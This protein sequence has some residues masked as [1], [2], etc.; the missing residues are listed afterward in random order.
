MGSSVYVT[1]QSAQAMDIKVVKQGPT[2]TYDDSLMAKSVTVA[3]GQSRADVLDI[4][5]GFTLNASDAIDTVEVQMSIGGTF[6]GA[7]VVMIDSRGQP[8]KNEIF[9]ALRS[10]SAA[11]TEFSNG[12]SSDTLS[13]RTSGFDVTAS[14]A[15]ESHGL[16]FYDVIVTVNAVAMTIRDIILDLSLQPLPGAK[17]HYQLSMVGGQFSVESAGGGVSA[18]QTSMVIQDGTPILLKA[19]TLPGAK[20]TIAFNDSVQFEM[21]LDQVNQMP[22]TITVHAGELQAIQPSS[23]ATETPI[24]LISPPVTTP[25]PSSALPA[26]NVSAGEQWIDLTNA[27]QRQWAIDSF[28]GALAYVSENS[29]YLWNGFAIF[30]PNNGNFGPRLV[31]AQLVNVRGAPRIVFAGYYR[32]FNPVFGPGFFGRGND[33]FIALINGAGTLDGGLAAVRAGIVPGV[34]SLIIFGL[35]TANQYYKLPD[36]EKTTTALLKIA[37]AGYVH[38]QAANAISVGMMSAV[39]AMLR[40]APGQP[41][42]RV[43]VVVLVAVNYFSGLIANY[44]VDYA[45]KKS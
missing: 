32:N 34:P 2:H 3:A 43:P 16:G 37:T 35:S 25:L 9:W 45:N 40:G 26:P 44:I 39:M 24:V 12:D 27:D 17:S 19:Q 15:G 28:G 38:N 42:P 10:A 33:R 41:R 1:N 6:I 14:I 29:Q 5:R 13:Y 23:T 30:N 7:V 11:L 36:E 18:L 21:P 4:S 31:T 8:L 20:M 22:L